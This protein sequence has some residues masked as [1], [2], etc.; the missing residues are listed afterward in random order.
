L[1]LR[2]GPTA[3]AA[4]RA[5]AESGYPLEV[6]GLL[7]GRGDEVREA[8]PCRNLNTERARDRYQMDPADQLRLEKDARA[9]GLDVLGYYHSHP[10]HPADASATD[11]AL[12][13]EGVHYL[14]VAVQQGKLVDQRLWWREQGAAAFSRQELKI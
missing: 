7:L 10:D 8:H 9:R 2:L 1:S 4:L 13:W 11:L 3:W 12:S 5:H 14:I 6:C